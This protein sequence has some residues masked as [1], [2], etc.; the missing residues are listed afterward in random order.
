MYKNIYWKWKGS[1]IAKTTAKK[2]NK[3]E[4][5]ILPE[6][7]LQSNSNDD[8]VVLAQTAQL[9]QWNRIRSH[10]DTDIY[11]DTWFMS[12]IILQ[13][14]GWKIVF[15]I[16]HAESIGYPYLKKNWPLPTWDTKIKFGC[17]VD[18]NVKVK[19]K[20]SFEIEL[21]KLSVVLNFW[22]FWPIRPVF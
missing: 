22:N 8:S 21:L 2:M 3:A 4:G 12:N 10:K 15:S 1:K 5:C 7:D 14:N 19:K 18:L 6:S 20:K 17:I 9:G 16:S 11:K 13:N